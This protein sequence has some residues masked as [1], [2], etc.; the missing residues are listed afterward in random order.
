MK[1]TTKG[2]EALIKAHLKEIKGAYPEKLKHTKAGAFMLAADADR[3]AGLAARAIGLWIKSGFHDAGKVASDLLRANPKDWTCARL[4]GVVEAAAALH[5]NHRWFGH[6]EW[7]PHRPLISAVEKAAAREPISPELRAALEHWMTAISPKELTPQ[8]E[9]E[10]GEAERFVSEDTENV[11]WAKVSAAYE[12]IERLLRIRSPLTNERKLI[13]RLSILVSGGSGAKTD[14]T[15]PLRIN[16]SDAVGATIAADV[17][18][19]GRAGGPAWAALLNHA[20][21]LTSTTPAEKWSSTAAEQAGK[22]KPDNFGACVSDW[23]NQAGKPAKAPVVCGEVRDA[24]LLN[25]SSVELLKG[26]AWA[27]VAAKR[28]DLA[29]ALGNLAEACFK[30]IPNKGP[31]NVKVANAATA[32]LAALADPAAAAQLSRLRL[33]VKHHSSRAT[34]DK[35]LATASRKTG[36]SPDDLAEMSVPAFGLN[37]RG[38]RR[39]DL[40]DHYAELRVA[41]AREVELRW[42][43][44]RGNACA[45]VPAAVRTKHGE[46]L[47][48]LK[49]EARDASTILAAQALRL[50]RSYVNERSWPLK[51]W[52]Q[53]F[54]DHPL[55]GTLARRLIWQFE[56][57]VAIPHEGQMVSAAGRPVSPRN[58]AAFSLWHPIGSPPEQ[59]LAWRAWLERHEVTQPF[60]QAYREIYV[61]TDAERQSGT[62]SNRFAAHI[63]RQHQLT[64]LCQARGWDYRLQGEFDSHNVPT[65]N[66]P[67]QNL[68]AEFWVEPVEGNVTPQGIFLCVSSDQVRFQRPLEQLPPIVFS[69][70]MRD[71]DLFV[72]VASIANDPTWQDGGPEGRQ[73]TYWEQWSF[74]ELS[75]SAR[76]RKAAL[77]QIVPKLKIAGQCSF[78]EKFLVVRGALRVYKIHLGSGNIQME[79]NNQYLCIVPDRGAAAKTGK[80]YLPFEGDGTLAVILSKA[81][82]LANDAEIK[83]ET[84][85]RQIT[86]V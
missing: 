55:V 23:L 81:F 3:R 66:L 40:R 44:R 65:L 52:R 13:E 17:A 12:T 56:D 47:K 16:A 54:L 85:R 50:E 58:D 2:E 64:A 26:L 33:R 78:D 68:S 72:S 67:T 15:P 53:R 31:R 32:A 83:D 48:Q 28:L 27:I 34:V 71:V 76:A 42:F 24:T 36:L 63:L 35:A 7:F 21:A 51:V 59:V 1:T 62:Y 29:P 4:V 41:S 20:R 14:K 8:E 69:E 79:P 77:E 45:S 39:V 57:S 82:L 22:I 49:R 10:L 5:R 80:L 73:R 38:V 75:E 46:V 9:R 70:V 74:G 86:P 43:D 6:F 30:K 11:P 19:G 61:L 60:K 18:K 25:D 37:A 84:I